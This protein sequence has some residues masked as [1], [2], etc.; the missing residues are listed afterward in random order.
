VIHR[1]SPIERHPFLDRTE[2]EAI[3]ARLPDHPELAR[4]QMPQKP[5]AF[6]TYGRAA[7]IDACRPGSDPQSGYHARVEAEN[8]R[9]ERLL[10]DLYPRLL[11]RF[12]EVVGEPAA[13]EP[14][15][16]G[17]PGIHVFRGD[18]ITAAAEEDGH[19][20]VQYR[21]LRFP[22]PPDDAEPISVTLPLRL[23]A[24]GG[25]LRVYQ[26][27]Y[28]DY[29]QGRPEGQEDGLPPLPGRESSVYEDYEVGV[30]V[31]HR[32]LYLHGI[33]APRHDYGSEEERIT[34]QCHGLRAGG[35]WW[36]YW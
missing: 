14:E 26:L 29:L 20:D 30:M 2:C 22:A 35:T 19:F 10:G 7:Y 23:P 1:R 34:L 3:C 32:G 17:L 11:S 27:T 24:G 4:Q 8:R 18:G 9:L 13:Y 25:G 5:G 31:L 6:V 28:S 12:E 15:L 21:P 36:I 33:A 16:L